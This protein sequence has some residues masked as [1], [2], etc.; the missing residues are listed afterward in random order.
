MISMEV[1]MNVQMSGIQT[2]I[3]TLLLLALAGPAMVMAAPQENAGSGAASQQAIP[4]GKGIPWSELGARA[5]KQ[6]SGEALSVIATETGARLRSDFQRLQGE[7]TAQGLA[8][9][10]SVVGQP[11]ERF[12]LAA[13][14]LG[15]EGKSAIALARL[16]GAYGSH[17]Q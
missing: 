1:V 5:G 3:T 6:Y 12:A 7:V 11:R 10:S 8:L 16:A 4:A 15:R 14:L 2:I 9:E 13:D 17:L